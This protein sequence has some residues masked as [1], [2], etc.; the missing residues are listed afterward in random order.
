MA[1]ELSFGSISKN[2]ILDHRSS[3]S[4]IKDPPTEIQIILPAKKIWELASTAGLLLF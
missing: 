3:G 1:I 2:L 4:P